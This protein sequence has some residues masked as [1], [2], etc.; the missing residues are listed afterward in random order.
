MYKVIDN[1]LSASHFEM[2]ANSIGNIPCY[3]SSAQE[4]L[5][6]IPDLEQPIDH[7]RM[8]YMARTISSGNDIEN[9]ELYNFYISPLIDILRTPYVLRSKINIFPRCEEIVCQPWHTDVV[10]QL[11]HTTDT[12]IFHVTT[13]DA[14]TGLIIECKEI[15]VPTVANRMIIIPSH[16]RH[17]GSAPTDAPIRC[18]VNITCMT[19]PPEAE[20]SNLY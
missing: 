18:T 12:C 9:K 2:Y 11:F 4:S 8:W 6:N 10:K 7:L 15:K 1:F 16:V 5:G 14:Y 13:C 17:H 19:P 3:Y 20:W